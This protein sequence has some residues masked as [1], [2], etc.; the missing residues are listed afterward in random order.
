MN[1]ITGSLSEILKQLDNCLGE[2]ASHTEAAGL[3]RVLSNSNDNTVCVA[4]RI[5]LE[6][7]ERERMIGE[8]LFSDPAWIIVLDLYVQSYRGEQVSISSACIASSA[9][10]STALRCVNHLE[11]KGW[12]TRVPDSSD[13]RR[14]FLQLT[15]FARDQ[16]CNYLLKVSEVGV[17]RQRMTE[18]FRNPSRMI[19]RAS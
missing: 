13:R 9:A 11:E 8:R 17:K 18:D 7:Y 10:M 16:I 3:A 5:L 15:N 6:A 2:I 4:E 14:H 12:V 19:G 1:Q